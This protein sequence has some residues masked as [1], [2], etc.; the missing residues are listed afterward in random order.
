MV[1]SVPQSNWLCFQC[2]SESLYSGQTQTN[3]HLIPSRENE[4]CVPFLCGITTQ[5]SEVYMGL[6]RCSVVVN[7][8]QEESEYRAGN[9]GRHMK[10]PQHDLSL[11]M[12]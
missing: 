1:F 4:G 2:P 5:L 3:E 12:L 7:S 8:S 11:Y 10:G 6:D 9:P